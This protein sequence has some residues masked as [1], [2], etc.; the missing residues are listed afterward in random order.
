MKTRGSDRIPIV[1][2]CEKCGARNYKTSRSKRP[3]AKPIE[4]RKHC[5]TCGVHSLHRESK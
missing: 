5:R 1:L 2:V 3:D 4:A